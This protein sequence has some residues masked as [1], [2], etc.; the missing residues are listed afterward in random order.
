MKVLYNYK[1]FPKPKKALYFQ[2][3]NNYIKDFKTG[4]LG[5]S[6]EEKEV[7]VIGEDNTCY[8]TELKKHIICD[9]T[10]PDYGK[11]VLLPIGF[12]KS[13]LIKWMQLPAEQLELFDSISQSKRVEMS[14][15]DYDYLPFYH[16]R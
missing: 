10:C 3:G 1:P 13:R 12:H 14:N 7:I 9:T 6:R 11:T 15:Q 8:I 5:W 4:V 16:G 2:T